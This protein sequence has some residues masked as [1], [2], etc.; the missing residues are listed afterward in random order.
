MSRTGR[1]DQLRF[2]A[3]EWERES[4]KL[5]HFLPGDKRCTFPPRLVSLKTPP[6][7][8][9]A[10]HVSFLLWTTKFR[11]RRVVFPKKVVAKI[12]MFIVLRCGGHFLWCGFVSEM[13]DHMFCWKRMKCFVSCCLPDVKCG[14]EIKLTISPLEARFLEIWPYK[15]LNWMSFNWAFWPSTES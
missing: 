12:C 10:T 3:K 7:N 6:P 11:T 2:I 15:Q 1:S 13:K 5:W 4:K 14:I 9:H 8:P